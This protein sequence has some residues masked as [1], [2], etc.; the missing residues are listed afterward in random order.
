M[1]V[2]AIAA[3]AQAQAPAPAAPKEKQNVQKQPQQATAE[4]KVP[5]NE[6]VK[7][8]EGKLWYH[9][10]GERIELTKEVTLGETKV[11]PD[12]SVVKKDGSTVQMKEGMLVNRNGNVIDMAA[13]KQKA[14][15]QQ[16]QK[17]AE[18]APQQPK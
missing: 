18:P 11:K 16:Q 6:Y 5:V 15:E 12:G 9:K 14:L 7:M 17:K 3:V 13:L 8:E 4:K 2:F 10:D 1:L